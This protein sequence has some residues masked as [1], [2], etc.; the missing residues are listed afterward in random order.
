MEPRS[1]PALKSTHVIGRPLARPRP[2]I[3]TSQPPGMSLMTLSTPNLKPPSVDR[4]QTSPCGPA[5]TTYTSPLGPTAGTAPITVL[6][7]SRQSPGISEMR[8]AGANDLPSSRE[9]DT[10]TW[11]L[12][13]GFLLP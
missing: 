2:L 1:L 7:L 5:Q 10:N 12:C 6:L 4:S 13:S 9:R 8:C 11:L 3:A